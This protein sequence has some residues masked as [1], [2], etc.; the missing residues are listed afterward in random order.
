[1]TYYLNIVI[2]VVNSDSFQTVTLLCITHHPGS[3][4]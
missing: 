4:V 1:M 3:W 2:E